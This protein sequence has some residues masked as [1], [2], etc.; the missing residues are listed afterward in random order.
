MTGERAR[1]VAVAE[2]LVS[3]ARSDYADAFEVQLPE[4]DARTAEQLLR[5]GLEESPAALRQLILIAH[6]KVLRL[7]L[8]PL[9]SPD[10]IL[11]WPITT[12]T[13]DVVR[14]DA[15]SPL[16]HATIVARRIAPGRARLTTSLRYA[17]PAV[18][19]TLWACVG[20]LHRQIA[21]YLLQ[22][23]AGAAR[24]AR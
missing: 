20:P 16:V 13:P 24:G 18:A 21:P 14:L 22:R 3:D 15:S 4:G 7:R 9:V 6:R 8:G 17:R 2:P 11:G 10:R 12:A 19:R 23:A 1:G 5:A